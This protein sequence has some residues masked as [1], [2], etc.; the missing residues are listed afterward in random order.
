MHLQVLNVPIFRL[1]AFISLWTYIPGSVP[2]VGEDYS[3]LPGDGRG[4]L[5]SEEENIF[6]MEHR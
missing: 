6:T 3:V 2:E 5:R 1:V 4:E